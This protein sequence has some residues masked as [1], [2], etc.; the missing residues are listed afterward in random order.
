MH[1]RIRAQ[2]MLHL[3]NWIED[4]CDLLSG[5]L[6]TPDAYEEPE[7]EQQEDQTKEGREDSYELSIIQE[8]LSC[9]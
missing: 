5:F 1:V 2:G 4:T 9:L 8:A 3:Q 7:Y 6:S